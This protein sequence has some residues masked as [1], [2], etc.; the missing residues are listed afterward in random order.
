RVVVR[1]NDM[2]SIEH[3]EARLKAWHDELSK[4]EEH[5]KAVEEKHAS[6][7][8]MLDQ[9]KAKIEM[10]EMARA[11]QYQAKLQ[12]LQAQQQQ[13]ALSQKSFEHG[14]IHSPFKAI[15]FLLQLLY[16]T[17]L[18]NHVKKTTESNQFLL[19]FMRVL[20]FT[21]NEHIVETKE[22]KSHFDHLFGDMCRRQ[23]LQ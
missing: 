13:L 21:Q 5:I 20:S 12:E 9:C 10:N 23:E 15:Y 7:S 4:R 19:R 2:T 16:F 1:K 22:R 8:T 6:E 17:F 3:K 11:Q 18:F 14:Y